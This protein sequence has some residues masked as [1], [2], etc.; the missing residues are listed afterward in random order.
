VAGFHLSSR[1]LIVPPIVALFVSDGSALLCRRQGPN[2]FVTEADRRQEKAR[3]LDEVDRLTRELR[4]VNEPIQR[5]AP[6]A[7]SV[8]G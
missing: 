1:V 3:L 8:N 7:T 6:L 2:P 4:G 5:R